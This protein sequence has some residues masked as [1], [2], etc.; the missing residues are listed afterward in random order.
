M[1]LTLTVPPLSEHDVPYIRTRSGKNYTPQSPKPADV[2]IEDVAHHLSMLCRFHGAVPRFYSVAEHSVRVSNLLLLNH[3]DPRLGLQ[4][5]MHD[6]HE[7]Y[8]Q[9]LASPL[10][11]FLPDYRAMEARNWAAVARA[12]HLPLVLDLRVKIA[13]MAMFEV[14]DRWRRARTDDPRRKAFLPRGAP[15]NNNGSKFGWSQLYAKLAF[16]RQF[17]YLRKAIATQASPVKPP[18]KRTPR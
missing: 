8:V 11:P 9:D 5:L 14:E 10:K 16:L 17:H 18:P 6:A 7:A 4:G 2:C 12:L 3:G 13:D 15:V 1:S